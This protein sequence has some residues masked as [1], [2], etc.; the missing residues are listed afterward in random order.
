MLLRILVAL[1][2]AFT[3][4]VPAAFMVAVPAKAGVL[5]LFLPKLKTFPGCHDPKVLHRI[6]YLFNEAEEDLWHRGL[7]MVEVRAVRERAELTEPRLGAHEERLIPRRY[8]TG[9]ARLNDAR[10]H[11]HPNRTV[12]YLIEGGQGFAGTH[13][14]VFF[15]IV[16]LDPWRVYDGRCEVLRRLN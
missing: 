4:A 2:L 9:T 12:F 3:V 16:G 13:Y 15:C 14:E 8:C 6:R 10:R 7:T 5:D 11:T 1:T